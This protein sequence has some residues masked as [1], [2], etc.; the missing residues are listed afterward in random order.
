M[1]LKP[2]VQPEK[3]LFD[4]R[5]IVEKIKEGEVLIRVRIPYRNF[6][7]AD[8]ISGLRTDLELSLGVF[9]KS[10]AKV[11]E[12][13]ETYTVEMTEDKLKEVIRMTTL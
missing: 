9:D 11:W 8:E 6:W 13:K 2:Q 4:F 7:F 12:F 10:G 3:I 1:D 5:V